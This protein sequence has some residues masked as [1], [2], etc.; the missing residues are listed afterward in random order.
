MYLYFIIL[1]SAFTSLFQPFYEQVTKYGRDGLVMVLTE[2]RDSDFWARTSPGKDDEYFRIHNLTNLIEDVNSA[3]PTQLADFILEYNDLLVQL[4][5]LT[6]D[7]LETS[8]ASIFANSGYTIL[9]DADALSAITFDATDDGYF[10]I[11]QE[12]RVILIANLDD[13]FLNYM[14]KSVSVGSNDGDCHG[15]RRYY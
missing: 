6:T 7:D 4:Y 8:L 2:V 11:K 14:L 13:T 9:T 10:T 5:G 1:I 15:F 12:V 3:T